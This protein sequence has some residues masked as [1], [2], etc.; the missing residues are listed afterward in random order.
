LKLVENPTTRIDQEASLTS[1]YPRNKPT[2]NACSVDKK[3]K[4]FVPPFLLAFKVFNINLHNYL[5]YSRE[6]SNVIPLSI[7]KKL[8]A[9]PLKSEKHV[10]QLDRTQVKVMGE[11]K[12]IMIRIETHPKFVQV[13]DIIVVD[14]PEAYSLL[15]I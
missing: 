13:I 9:V 8:N 5:V 15:L 6:P 2:V 11:L 14:I 3:G 1:T 12:D 10:I 4:P 7:C